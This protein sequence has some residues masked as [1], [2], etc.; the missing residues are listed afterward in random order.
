LMW[1]WCGVLLMW[2]CGFMMWCWLC[3]V[4]VVITDFY[5]EFF[6]TQWEY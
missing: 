2:W 5:V 4:C 1:C 6:F 3:V